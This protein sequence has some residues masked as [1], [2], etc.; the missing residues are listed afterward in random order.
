MKLRFDK[1]FIP[2]LFTMLNL[3]LGI[4]SIL[5]SIQGRYGRAGLFIFGAGIL[6]RYDG[7]IAR[8]L[9]A[10]SDLGRQLD[11]F[12]DNTSFG[13]AP[14]ILIYQQQNLVA[15]DPFGYLAIAL[16]CICGTYRLARYNSTSFTGIFS[17]VPI[18]VIGPA[19]TLITLLIKVT[20]YSAPLMMALLLVGG[21][22]MASSLKVRKL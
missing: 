20:D 15:Y 6:D 5:E 7:R 1:S 13:V 4:L 12:A 8:W 18:T 3:A 19:L 22:L 10:E 14:A 2:N 9:D 21:W 11:S 16:F 17:G